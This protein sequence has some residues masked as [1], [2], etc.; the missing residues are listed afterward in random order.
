M[1]QQKGIFKVKGMLGDVSFYQSKDGYLIR[2]K[3]SLDGKRI[4]TDPAFIRTRENSAEFSRGARSGKLVRNAFRHLI[5]DA[6]DSLVVSRLTRMM[7]EC[8]R[9]DST[10]V[11][12]ERTVL[13]N[14]TYIKGFDFN[15]NAKLSSTLYVPYQAA[16]DKTTGE[17]GV[18]M[19]AY[20][21]T[22][23][24]LAPQGTTHYQ[25][26]VAGALLNFDDLTFEA[27]FTDGAVLAYDQTEQS[28]GSLSVALTPG[29][30][31]P[32][33]L[34]MGITFSQEVNGEHYALKNGVYNALSLVEVK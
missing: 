9:L 3:T 27:R 18:N 4:A 21:A 34:V 33:M 23:A 2:E 5:K 12:G 28:A 26:H 19:E 14:I 25:L 24:I 10:H 32:Y 7:I 16:V 30:V 17:L 20:R 15:N 31:N 1:A 29:S 6:S 13:E 8:L 11:R 22:A